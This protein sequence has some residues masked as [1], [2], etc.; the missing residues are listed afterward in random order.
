[1]FDLVLENGF[2]VSHPVVNDGDYGNCE[3]AERRRDQAVFEGQ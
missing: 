3:T 2:R 1:M